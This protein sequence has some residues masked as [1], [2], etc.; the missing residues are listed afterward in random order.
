MLKHEYTTS[1]I[2]KTERIIVY[3]KNVYTTYYNV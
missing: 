1:T 2:M 3:L